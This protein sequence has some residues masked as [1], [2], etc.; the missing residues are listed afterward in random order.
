MIQYLKGDY[1][2]VINS[3][4]HSIK[5]YQYDDFSWMLKAI[6]LI[7]IGLIIEGIECLDKSVDL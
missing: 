1:Q 4:N 5:L 7:N 3:I 2:L 6:S